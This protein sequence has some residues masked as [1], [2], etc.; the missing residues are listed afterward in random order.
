MVEATHEGRKKNTRG[1]I[2]NNDQDK[3]DYY[4]HIQYRPACKKTLYFGLRLKTLYPGRQREVYAIRS[5]NMQ[6]RCMQP[7]FLDAISYGT[8]QVEP[9]FLMAYILT[10]GPVLY[11]QAEGKYCKKCRTIANGIGTQSS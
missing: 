3:S 10:S 6:L 7:N 8:Q 4:E 1:V 9:Q 5:S 11:H 2:V